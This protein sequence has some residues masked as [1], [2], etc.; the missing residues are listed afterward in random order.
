MASHVFKIGHPRVFKP[1]AGALGV[2]GQTA[3]LRYGY[4][5]PAAAGGYGITGQVATPRYDRILAPAA[6]S[7][8]Q[9]GQA[10][11]LTKSG[12]AVTPLFYD[13][14]ESGDDSHT[15]NG[16]SWQA[17]SG[18]AEHR[19]NMEDGASPFSGNYSW[20]FR[21]DSQQRNRLIAIGG[22]ALTEWWFDYRI[23]IPSNYNHSCSGG[24]NNKWTEFFYLPDREELLIWSEMWRNSAE[25]GGSRQTVIWESS[26]HTTITQNGIVVPGERG[27]WHRWRYHLK[28]TTIDSDT[29]GI[30]YQAWK[31]DTELYNNPNIVEPG[32]PS[33]AHN[34]GAFQ[35]MG[36]NNCNFTG[37]TM[38]WYVDNATD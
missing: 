32:V 36:W 13:G 6:G 10:A 4:S 15:E 3:T 29:V 23:R 33:F 31:D 34:V 27:E 19:D 9:T 22:P 16:Y 12:G 5:L 28:L 18:V 20:R 25:D 38:T 26:S 21:Q 35:I 8:V 2:T 11:T 30:W 24:Q 1:L 7:Y 37:G 14:F 17:T